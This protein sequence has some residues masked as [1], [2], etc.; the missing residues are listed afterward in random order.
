MGVRISRV[1]DIE[2]LSD[3]EHERGD[4]EREKGGNGDLVIA[5]RRG[6]SKK[7]PVRGPMREQEIYYHVS[8]SSI[9]STII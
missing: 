4:H 3:I 9:Y 5:P 2:L 7:G 6:N 1:A 8:T